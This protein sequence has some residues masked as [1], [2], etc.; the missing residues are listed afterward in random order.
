MSNACFQE[1]S[2]QKLYQLV[3]NFFAS[4][5]TFFVQLDLATLLCSSIHQLFS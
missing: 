2:G 5:L 3:W 1:S 4:G